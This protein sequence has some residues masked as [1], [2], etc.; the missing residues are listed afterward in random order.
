[1]KLFFESQSDKIIGQKY[2]PLHA[3]VEMMKTARIMP[4]KITMCK[5]IHTCL[6]V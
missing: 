1:M 2:L 6:W 3:I 4:K 5:L